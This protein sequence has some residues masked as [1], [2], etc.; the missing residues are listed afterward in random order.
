MLVNNKLINCRNN[1]QS[2]QVDWLTRESEGE[3]SKR[4]KSTKK[5][6]ESDKRAL[7]RERGKLSK[8]KPIINKGLHALSYSMKDIPTDAQVL[9]YIIQRD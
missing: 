6:P 5:E 1:W 4:G 2:C 3:K 8:E 7:D 9:E